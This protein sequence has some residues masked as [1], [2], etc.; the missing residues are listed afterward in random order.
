MIL[1]C[2][3]L[4]ASAL[5]PPVGGVTPPDGTLL[6]GMDIAPVPKRREQAE[7]YRIAS[8]LPPAAF[9]AAYAVAARRAGYET[10]SSARILV[11]RRPA[12]GGFRLVLRPT[13]EGTAG[14]LTVTR[15]S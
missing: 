13:R 15:R 3:V 10:T 9:R 6:V 12:G 11:G 2:L 5:L 7:V 8:P 14:V 4:V 1:A